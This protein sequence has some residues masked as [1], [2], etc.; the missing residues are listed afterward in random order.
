MK[1]KKNVTKYLALYMVIG[2]S[3]G[4]MIG[5]MIGIFLFEDNLALGM[6]IGLSTGMCIGMGVGAAKDK[7]LSEH[8]MEICRVEEVLDS[9]DLLVYAVGKEGTEKEYKV[10]QKQQKE[11][12]FSVGDRV[13]EEK[14]GR[15]VSLETKEPELKKKKKKTE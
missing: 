14:D 4:M 2:M 1:E 7:R 9:S 10:T 3:L 8:M 13:A 5:S 12:M 15:L 11:E 6:C